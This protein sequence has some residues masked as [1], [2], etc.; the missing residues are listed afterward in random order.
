MSETKKYPLGRIPSPPD[1]RDYDLRS[2]I[3]MIKSDIEKHESD[4]DFPLKSLD[5][6]ETPHCFPSGTLVRMADG[7]S[8][9][10]EA[11]EQGDKVLSAEGNI[12]KVTKVM[13]R[14]YNGKLV[15]LKLWGH[16]HLYCT[17][18]HP[19]L[20]KEGYVKAIDLKESDFVSI[21]RINLWEKDSFLNLNE[22][23]KF[24]DIERAH[25]NTVFPKEK[26]EKTYRLGRLFGLYLAEG[27]CSL[28]KSKILFAFNIDERYTLVQETV[29]S[30]KDIF[31][32]EAKLEV[33]EH[34]NVIIVYFYGA[35]WAKL[36]IKLFGTGCQNKKIAGILLNSSLDFQKGILE[37]WLAGDGHF[38][39]TGW[40]GVT[41][42]KHL[43]HDIF[44]IANNLG[45]M[46]TISFTIPNKNEYAESRLPRWDIS[47]GV[48]SGI[49]NNR[50]RGWR[51]QLDEKATWR[52]VKQIRFEKEYSGTVY[53]LEVE[54]D[55]SYIAEGIGVHN[56]VGFSAA[57]WGINSPTNTEFANAD[58]HRFYYE[59]KV[60]E[61]Q[62]G[63]E[64][65]AYIRSIG[66]VLKANKHL[67]AYAFAPDINTI[68]YWLLYKGPIIAG[69]IWK[70]GMFTPDENNVIHPT[71]SSMG[72]HAYLLNE[73]RADDYIGIQNSWGESWGKNGKAYISKEDFEVIFAQGGEALA[74]V[75]IVKCPQEAEE[76]EKKCWLVEFFK[77]FFNC[78]K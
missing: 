56:C 43:A 27:Y 68:K 34:S 26:V 33:R 10:I 28:D 15:N 59:C 73:W 31:G 2:F 63:E 72:G 53:N 44:F 52:K 22:I 57:S 38:R 49:E 45:Y 69:T 13:E 30:L 61:G 58:G 21:P 9:V 75:E 29:D 7:S 1:P 55:N 62:P 76:T 18:E 77:K 3:P 6:K 17:P 20:T 16:N 39:R 70:E 42:S 41:V 48:A 5:Q 46:P 11:I 12:C 25:K 24:E 37:G 67:E 50:S 74:A 65:G 47:F 23:I 71:G 54:K 8:K 36:F 4:W 14:E 35:Y 32:I 64:N 40:Q 60:V 19:I 66:K 51:T 78:L